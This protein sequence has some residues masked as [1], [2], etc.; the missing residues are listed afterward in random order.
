M[1]LSTQG[2]N[3]NAPYL[4]LPPFALALAILALFLVAAC[5]GIADAGA[6]Y[7]GELCAED[8]WQER[9]NV[10]TVWGGSESGP[11]RVLRG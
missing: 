2:V 3:V 1:F 11:Q 10:A 8:L 7:C 9:L 4:H 6:T 5:G